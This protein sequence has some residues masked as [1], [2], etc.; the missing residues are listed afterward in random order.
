M[1][2]RVGAFLAAKK[3]GVNFAQRRK[4]DNE[5]LIPLCE[6]K[7]SAQDRD[8]AQFSEDKLLFRKYPYT[9]WLGGLWVCLIG[10]FVI[11]VLN[12]ELS[13]AEQTWTQW[14]ALGFLISLGLAFMRSGRII[15]TEFEG[16]KRYGTVL[17]SRTSLFCD[18][19]F[20]C[21][22]LSE[23]IGVKAVRRGQRTNSYNTV[24]F[25]LIVTVN[26]PVPEED[27]N[28]RRLP[29][30]KE[31][32]VFTTSNELRVKKGLL[33]IRQFLGRDLDAALVVKDEG[34]AQYVPTKLEKFR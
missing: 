11:Y 25:A 33:A 30:C 32:I 28:S 31:I 29:T 17:V 18:R 24:Y 4:T 26:L 2:V 23:I 8:I 15:T 9:E 19:D 27:E 10:V 3:R 13:H 6:S 14:I 22:P 5:E 16:C 7:F 34:S 1:G 21:Y 12:T 20:E